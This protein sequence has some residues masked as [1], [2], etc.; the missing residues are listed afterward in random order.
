MAMNWSPKLWQML[1][2]MQN[3][4][5]FEM[6]QIIEISALFFLVLVI[7]IECGLRADGDEF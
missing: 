4:M 3:E 5:T 1:I 6:Q 7:A 2:E